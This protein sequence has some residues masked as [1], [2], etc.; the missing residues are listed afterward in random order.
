MTVIDLF[1]V[2]HTE[3][4][5]HRQLT[6]QYPIDR[7]SHTN[8]EHNGGVIWRG[9]LRFFAKPTTNYGIRWRVWFIV[10]RFGKVFLGGSAL[11]VK[12]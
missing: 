7:G 11:N 1:R 2:F 3:I 8:A 4:M 9:F 6:C 12:A 10:L 5:M